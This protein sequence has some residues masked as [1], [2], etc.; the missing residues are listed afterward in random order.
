MTSFAA[1]VFVAHL[2]AADAAASAQ[3]WLAAVA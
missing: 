1:S 3:F 2:A